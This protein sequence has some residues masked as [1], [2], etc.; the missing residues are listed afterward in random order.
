LSGVI[1]RDIQISPKVSLEIKLEA[2]Q[3]IGI[4]PTKRAKIVSS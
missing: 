1:G 4:T 3:A 2:L